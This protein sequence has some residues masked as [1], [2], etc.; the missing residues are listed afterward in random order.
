MPFKGARSHHVTRAGYPFSG[1]ATTRKPVAVRNWLAV[2]LCW[3]VGR[4]RGGELRD[5]LIGPRVD[6][7]P[8]AQVTEL[9]ACEAEQPRS[10]GG[11]WLA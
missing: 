7:L 2:R 4:R 1:T 10:K 5:D 9:P 6:G 8:V 11:I 3:G